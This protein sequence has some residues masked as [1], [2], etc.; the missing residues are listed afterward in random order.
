MIEMEKPADADEFGSVTIFYPS[1]IL[2]KNRIVYRSAN[3]NL[4]ARLERIVKLVIQYCNAQTI[5]L[6]YTWQGVNNAVLSDSF[7]VRS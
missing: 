2:P 1:E 4:N 3:G 6:L 7:F 5:D